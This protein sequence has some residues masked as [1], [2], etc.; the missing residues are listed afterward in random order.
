M[1]PSLIELGPQSRVP[2][3]LA[4]NTHAYA[5]AFNEVKRLGGDGVVTDT[6]RDL[7]QTTAGTFWA[8]DGTPS[9]CAPPRLYNQITIQ[10]AE[11]MGSNFLDLTRLLALVNVAMA[12]AGIA[13]WESKYF[14]E[15]WRPVTGIREA[16]PGRL[17]RPDEATATPRRSGTRHVYARRRAGEQPR[18]DPTSHRR[19]RLTRRAMR[20]SEARS[21]KSC[22]SSTA[23]TRSSSRSRRMSTTA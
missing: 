19:F 20:A 9:L 13:I 16:D 10:I 14:Y 18:R 12:D 17:G 3:L 4:L 1:T 2:P 5:V 23:P 8:Y 15:F 6:E 11:Q 7:E 21:S 22:D